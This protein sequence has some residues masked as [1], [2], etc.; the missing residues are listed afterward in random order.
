MLKRAK[1]AECEETP[2]F[3][4]KSLRSVFVNK[5]YIRR[6]IIIN[7]HSELLKFNRM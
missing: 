4:L 1:L 6:C 2:V 5:Y 3:F 7:H